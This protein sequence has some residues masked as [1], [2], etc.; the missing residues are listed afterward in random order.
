[1]GVGIKGAWGAQAFSHSTT[2]LA[3][4]THGLQL[5]L[6]PVPPTLVSEAGGGGRE[7]GCHAHLWFLMYLGRFKNSLCKPWTDLTRLRE[8]AHQQPCVI[9]GETPSFSP[10]SANTCGESERRPHRGGRPLLDGHVHYK[11]PEAGRWESSTSQVWEPHC[12]GSLLALV[13]SLMPRGDRP[14]SRP[15]PA[16]PWPDGCRDGEWH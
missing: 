14:S 9:S 10:A 12:P 6:P 1:M 11:A 3:N 2:P 5:H 15:G 7:R 4:Y 13:P 16:T 8:C